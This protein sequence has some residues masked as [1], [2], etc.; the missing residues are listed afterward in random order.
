MAGGNLVTSKQAKEIPGGGSHKTSIEKYIFKSIEIE[1]MAVGGPKLPG[2][3]GKEF[4]IKMKKSTGDYFG[5]KVAK[6][7]EIKGLITKTAKGTSIKRGVRGSKSFTVILKKKASIGGSTGTKT[8]SIPM[9][10]G[11]TILGFYNFLDNLPEHKSNIQAFRTPN[12][13]KWSYSS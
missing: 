3:A 1:E 6:T 12:G 9:P 13:E 8:L 5:L 2:G 4:V 10:A 7:E 11:T